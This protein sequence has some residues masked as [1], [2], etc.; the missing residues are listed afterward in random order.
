VAQEVHRRL[1][2]IA[3]AADNYGVV[4]DPQ[5]FAVDEEATEELRAGK[6]E[7]RGLNTGETTLDRGGTVS[8]LLTRCEE[9]TGH[10]PPVPQWEKRVYGPHAG[11]E[12]VRNWFERMKVEGMDAFDKA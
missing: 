4:V 5:T 6:R 12:Y 10:K 3:G 1:V 8:E 9:E 7:E 2:T 11:L